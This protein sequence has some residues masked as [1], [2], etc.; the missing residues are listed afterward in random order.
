MNRRRTL[1]LKR[2]TLSELTPR[3]LHRVVGGSHLCPITDA[4]TDAC[5][6]ESFDTPCQTI[7]INPCLSNLACPDR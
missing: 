5:T 2:E 3:E 1:A 6:H 7:P 4:C